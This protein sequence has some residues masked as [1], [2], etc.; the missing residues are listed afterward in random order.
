[1]FLKSEGEREMEE[2]EVKDG[3]IEI[4]VGSQLIAPECPRKNR[5]II[6][7]HFLP[8]GVYMLIG[9]VIVVFGR[10]DLINH[11]PF[12]EIIALHSAIFPPN[13]MP[14]IRTAWYGSP[15]RGV[16][17]LF[18]AVMWLLAPLVTAQL[19]YFWV[20]RVGSIKLLGC[21]KKY[22]IA[23][24]LIFI[25][26]FLYALLSIHGKPEEIPNPRIYVLSNYKVG[27]AIHGVGGFAGIVYFASGWAAFFIA[28]CEA[29]INKVFVLKT[30]ADS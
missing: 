17:A 21:L 29:I 1:M 27:L 3:V 20:N 6:L 5:E 9:V 11:T 8:L 7:E 10:N 18:S 4:G 22:K 12:K 24:L 30:K 23:L 28:V 2:K 15:I 19:T 25:P 13:M 14:D 26:L 16:V